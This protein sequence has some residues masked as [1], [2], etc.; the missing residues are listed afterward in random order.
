MKHFG[1]KPVIIAER[2]QFHRR[3]QAIGETVAE[4]EAELHKLATHC[5]FGD[6]LSEAIRDRIVYGLC[7]ENIQKCLLAEDDLTLVK[8]IEI[9]QGMEAANHN[10]LRLRS[11][12][13]KINEVTADSKCCY[14]CGSERHKGKDCRHRDTECNNCKKKG[15]LA[16]MCRSRTA[17]NTPSQ[18]GKGKNFCKRETHW[19]A[20]TEDYEHFP[21]NAILTVG[22]HGRNRPITVQLELNGQQVLM[23]VD[24]GAAVSIISE[25]TQQKLFPDAHLEQSSVQLQTYTVLQNH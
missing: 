1:P 17:Q 14:R 21:D 20:T 11:S 16:R 15:H 2:F 25:A 13:L 6:Y 24:T 4:Y 8:T 5:A 22:S 18:S 7:N 12:E 10:A 19:V 23:Q 3:N 9:A